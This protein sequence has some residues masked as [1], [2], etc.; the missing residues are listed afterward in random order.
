MINLYRN[1]STTLIESECCKGLLDQCSH[2]KSFGRKKRKKRYEA[3]YLFLNQ[4]NMAKE[5]RMLEKTCINIRRG[6]EEDDDDLKVM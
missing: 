1:S 2:S 4:V 5:Q 6:D 3:D